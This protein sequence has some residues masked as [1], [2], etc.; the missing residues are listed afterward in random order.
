[1]GGWSGTADATTLAR[2]KSVVRPGTPRCLVISGRSSGSSAG[3]A[4]RGEQ[5]GTAVTA[6]SGLYRLDI[7]DAG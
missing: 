1:M 7:S 4:G 5:N 6:Y 3:I 2:L